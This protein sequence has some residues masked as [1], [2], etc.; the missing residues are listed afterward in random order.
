MGAPDLTL[1][2]ADI[3]VDDVT[4]APSQPLQ[5]AV[6]VHNNG[7]LPA[8]NVPVHLFDGRPENGVVVASGTIASIP[9]GGSTRRLTFDTTAVP[10]QHRLWAVVDWND[11]HGELDEHNNRSFTDLFVGSGYGE[12][13]EGFEEVVPSGSGT[14]VWHGGESGQGAWLADADVPFDANIDLCRQWR[15][16]RTRTEA[17][18]G[19]S[20]LS[21]YFNGQ[22]DD[23]TI[24]IER[25]VPVEPKSEVTVDLSW[26]FG[27]QANMATTPVYYIGMLDPEGEADFTLEPMQDG[28]AEYHV[29]EQVDTGNR[30]RL[31][32]AVGFTVSWETEVWHYLDDVEISVQ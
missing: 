29:T 11:V 21:M 15:I 7:T 13:V 12:Y 18:T 2:P 6:T 10:G 16:M 3:R 20:G 5:V 4:P 17:Y 27:I 19:H 22:S 23:G 1:G 32:V 14:G 30:T 31:W 9:A 26:A 24:W 25:W 8:T 28:W